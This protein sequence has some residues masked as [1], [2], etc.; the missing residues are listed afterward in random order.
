M[1]ALEEPFELVGDVLG[2]EVAGYSV[3]QI[4]VGLAAVGGLVWLARKGFQKVFN[5]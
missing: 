5:G 4:G 3:L 1:N 2:A